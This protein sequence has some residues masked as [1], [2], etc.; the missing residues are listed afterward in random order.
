MSNGGG[1]W[2][3][4]WGYI[5]GSGGATGVSTPCGFAFPI[6]QIPFGTV[7]GRAE[8]ERFTGTPD[9]GFLTLGTQSP[10][11]VYFSPALL[12]VRPNNQIDIDSFE[13]IT[14]A[15]EIYAQPN[16]EN[17]RLFKFGPNSSSRT[18]NSLYR[19]QPSEYTAVGT[20]TQTLPPGPT[21][22]YGIF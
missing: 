3:T 21:V 9:S 4:S 22:V 6:Y 5:W 11:L 18:N 13:I 7:L 2:G 12:E 16:Q 17:N 1:S 10:G 8:L 15:F 19:S 20:L 14:R